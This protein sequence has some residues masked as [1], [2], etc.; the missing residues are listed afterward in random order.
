MPHSYSH[1]FPLLNRPEYPPNPELLQSCF[2]WT[3]KLEALLNSKHEHNGKPARV[4]VVFDR[5]SEPKEKFLKYIYTK[6]G[7]SKC[8]ISHEEWAGTLERFDFSPD[9]TAERP[10][11]LKDIS[12]A[13]S[14]SISGIKIKKAKGIGVIPITLHA[15]LSQNPKG[16]TSKLGPANYRKIFDQFYFL[17]SQ[18]NTD[19]AASRWVRAI[20]QLEGQTILQRFDRAFAAHIHATFNI[21]ET[22]LSDVL[23]NATLDELDATP[24]WIIEHQDHLP[25]KWFSGAWDKLTSDEWK[26]ALPPRRWSDWA[27]CVLRTVFGLGFLWEARFFHELA[28]GILVGR[29][30]SQILNSAIKQDRSDLAWKPQSKVSSRDISSFVKNT[31]RLGINARAFMLMDS[32]QPVK[33]GAMIGELANYENFHTLLDWISEFR[34]DKHNCELL[35]NALKTNYSGRH[36]SLHETITYSLGCREN[37]GPDADFYGLFKNHGNRY[38]VINPSP[39]WP[40]VIASLSCKKPATSTNMGTVMTNLQKLGI[41][42]SYSTLTECLET[43]G[44]CHSCHDADQAVEVYSAF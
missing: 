37:I 2:A 9:P 31:V 40:V 25:F 35:T 28:K 15:A 23:E 24:K 19:S 22:E 29:E 34:N 42:T 10:A 3:P 41:N 26:Q 30:P 38:K 32:N 1:L 33:G 13:I 8:P 4:G 7:S 43:A 18:S 16:V 21:S 44:L 5:H 6:P 14:E 12:E 11:T 27:N 20:R 39:E 36:K 17:G